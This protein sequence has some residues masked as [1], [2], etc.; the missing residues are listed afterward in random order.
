MWKKRGNVG[1]R[2][3]GGGVDFLTSWKVDELE[4]RG[5]HS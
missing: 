3:E 5:N 2:R 4:K 1:G